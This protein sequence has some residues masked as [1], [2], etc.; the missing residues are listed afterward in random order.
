MELNTG[1]QDRD[2]IGALIRTACAI[3]PN[4]VTQK[5]SQVVQVRPA[6]ESYGRKAVK[7]HLSLKSYCAHSESP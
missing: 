1:A 3:G 4:T 6:T 7:W 2:P 5:D